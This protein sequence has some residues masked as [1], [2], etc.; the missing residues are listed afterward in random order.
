MTNG[1]CLNTGSTYLTAE[2]FSKSW[3]STAKSWQRIW[4]LFWLASNPSPLL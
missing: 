2:S 1:N 4:H 3:A